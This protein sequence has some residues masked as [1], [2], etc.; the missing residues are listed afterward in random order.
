M[1]KCRT[2]N[3]LN[4]VDRWSRDNLLGMNGTPCEPIPGKPSQHI[5][6]DVVDDG[7]YM[8]LDSEN[9]ELP[10]EIIND[11]VDEQEFKM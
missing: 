5:P 9:E 7:E 8:G 4:E 3:R 10:T 1:I 11:E 2:V 6:V